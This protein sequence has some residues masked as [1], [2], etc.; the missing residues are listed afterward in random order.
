MKEQPR[1]REIKRKLHRCIYMYILMYMGRY[2]KLHLRGRA[3]K[4][5]NALPTVD[6]PECNERVVI[7]ARVLLSR[8]AYTYIWIDIPYPNRIAELH[9]GFY[10]HSG[11]PFISRIPL[12]FVNNIVFLF[13]FQFISRSN[14]LRSY[15]ILNPSW[16]NTLNQMEWKI[17]VWTVESYGLLIP[18]W[19]NCIRVIFQLSPNV[20]HKCISAYTH[21]NKY[22]DT[23]TH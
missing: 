9:S 5:D 18:F 14:K 19:Y 20:G 13:F 15:Y 6:A 17:H 7:G 11:D 3:V 2:V 1:V 23:Y 4:C 10:R 8:S 21:T 16:W 22:T 12:A